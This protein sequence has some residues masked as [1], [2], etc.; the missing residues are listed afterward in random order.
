MSNSELLELDC[1]ILMPS[2]IQSQI[3]KENADRIKASMVVEGANGPTSVEADKILYD[4][5]ILVIPDILANAGGVVTSY[6]EWV[7]DLQ[8]FFWEEEQVNERLARI[9]RN[10]YAG[11]L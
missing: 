2:A 3:T 8:N 9:M 4:K 10:S 5:G 6:F 11:R 1:D 7:Q